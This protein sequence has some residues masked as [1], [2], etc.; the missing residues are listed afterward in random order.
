M[1]R[2]S[3]RPKRAERKDEQGRMQ[4]RVKHCRVRFTVVVAIG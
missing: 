3:L 4:H 2:Y 1:D